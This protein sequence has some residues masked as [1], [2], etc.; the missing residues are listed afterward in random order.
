M[1]SGCEF[2]LA[3]DFCRHYLTVEDICTSGN[4][5][6]TSVFGGL[7]RASPSRV[8]RGHVAAGHDCCEGGRRRVCVATYN[9]PLTC[10][11]CGASLS[12]IVDPADGPDLG[13]L[14]CEHAHIYQIDDPDDDRE[15]QARLGL[16]Y[17]DKLQD[18]VPC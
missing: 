1:R 16:A 17:R 15:L 10:P 7:P 14:V 5:T 9:V 12:L 13:V 8:N 6:C 18:R 3:E 2:R 4:A 11:G